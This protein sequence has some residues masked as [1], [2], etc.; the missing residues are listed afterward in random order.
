MARRRRKRRNP[1]LDT[2]EKVLWLGVGAVA[3]GA[4]GYGVY[5]MIQS[6]RQA[7][8]LSELPP[9]PKDAMGPEGSSAPQSQCGDDY[10]GFVFD[11]VGCIPGATTPAGIYVAE[12][13][14]DFVFV[15]GDI[16][17]QLDYLEGVI[18]YQA[19]LHRPS[20]STSADPIEL[21]TNFFQNFWWDCQWP[22]APS[23]PQR[24]VQ[25]YQTMVYV[26]GHEIMAAGGRVLGTTD[27]E[28][29]DEQ[30]ADRLESM[31]Y[32]DFNPDVVPEISIPDALPE[33]STGGSGGFGGGQ[34]S[35]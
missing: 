35:L 14:S 13:C 2:T 16:G 27:P 25:L 17:P 5:R 6:R 22:P 4:G 23:G 30:I 24:I 20:G 1:K 15:E 8:A 11:G 7:K 10:P 9:P 19:Q 29:I 18:E 31:G 33:P 28:V 21:T 34:V 32:F 12:K 3:L 26:I